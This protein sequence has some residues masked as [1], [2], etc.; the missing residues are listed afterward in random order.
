MEGNYKARRRIHLLRKMLGDF[1]I[2][3][4]R[5]RLEWVSASEGAR[6]AQVVADF[7]KTL[8]ELGPL[9]KDAKLAVG[10]RG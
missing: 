6:F 3:P 2:E 7:T 4:E 9:K 8:K 1:G 5:V 10:Q